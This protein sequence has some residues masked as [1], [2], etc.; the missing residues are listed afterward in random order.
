MTSLKAKVWWLFAE[1][2]ARHID[3]Y[4]VPQY[5]DHGEDLV[6]DYSPDECV[7]QIEKYAR[8]LAK[9]SS[10]PGEEKRDLMKIAHYAQMAH[11]KM[12]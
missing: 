7:R 3:E 12:A 9:G 4:V 11:D 8:R 2:V 10:R 6:A 1:K 5:G